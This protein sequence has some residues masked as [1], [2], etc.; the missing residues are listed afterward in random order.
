MKF[1]YFNLSILLIIASARISA[2]ND[3]LLV[4]IGSSG[5]TAEEFQQRFELIPQLTAGVKKDLAQKKNDL[6][7]SLIAEKL[8]ANEAEEL[9]L[10]TSDIMQTTFKTIEKMFVRDALYKIEVTD[11]IKLSDEKKLEGLKRIYF[12]LDLDVLHFNDSVSA[13]KVYKLIKN[14][15]TFDSAK[16]I[17]RSTLQSVQIKYGELKESIEDIL[18]GLKEG[19]FTTPVKSSS[20]WLI[21]KLLKKEPAVFENRDQAL[22]K[23]EAIIKQRKTDKYYDEF[24]RKFFG[25]RKVETDGILFWS[26]A[27]K[28][29]ALLSEKK[30]SNSIPDNENVY[31]DVNDLLKIE[32]ELGSDTLKISFIKFDKD[33]VSVKQFLRQFIFEGFYSANVKPDI[34]AAKLNSRVRTFIEQELLA[35]EGYNRGLQ[36]LPEVKSSISMWRDNYLAKIFKNMLVDSVKITDE[37]IHDYYSNRNGIRDSSF[38]EVNILEILTD[39]LEVIESVLSDLEKGADFRKLASAHTKRSWTRNNGGEFGFFPI[40]MYGDIGRIAAQMNIGDIYGPIKLPEGYSV[41]KLIDKRKSVVDTALSFKKSKEDIR[42]NLTY[43][44][45]SDFFID[46]TVKLANKYGVAINEQLL[47]TISVSDLNVFVY[48]YMGFGGRIN[49]VPMALPFTEWVLPWKESK[50]LLP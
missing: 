37:E 43:K 14:G 41:F 19:D 48:R 16:I 9:K 32:M 2:A 18:Y 29:T 31:L 39:S 28:I 42:K 33:P 26:I 7:F 17:S 50:K 34:V 36:N 30:I 22:I 46:Y 40:T 49:A 24:Y 21:F 6:L 44:K 10:D 8:W 45:L 1:Y 35:R 47:N 3:S 11:K 5:I 27:D 20:G 12:N 4:K 38:M 25:S 13:A 15:V 23:V